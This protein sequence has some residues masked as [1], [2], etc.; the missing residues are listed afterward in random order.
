MTR[1]VRKAVFPVGGL[2]TRFLPA[3]KAVPKEMLPVV[4]KPLIQYAVEEAQRQGVGA[5]Y[6]AKLGGIRD[7]RFS[8]QIVIEVEVVN[9]FDAR[10]TLTGHIGKNMPIDMGP[11]AVLAHG[12]VRI[13]ITSRSGPQFAPDF[14]RVAGFDPFA[15]S[16]VVAKSPCGFRAAYQDRAAAIYMLRSPGCAPSDFWNYEY[17][18]IPRPLW[19]WDEFDWSPTA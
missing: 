13:L 17:R 2:G 7:T 19:P 18:N 11:S 14:F 8:M 6:R 4:D 9:L 10:F 12:D 16:V 15:A 3:T 5:K 1:P